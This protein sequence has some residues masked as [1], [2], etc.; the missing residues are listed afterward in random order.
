MSDLTGP[1]AGLRVV[2]LA[3][4]QAAMAA[5]LLG[6]LGAEVIVVEPPGGHRTRTY[7]PFVDDQPN[8]E[9]CLWWWYYNASKLGV[10]IDIDTAVGAATFGKLIATADIVI[11]G[12][13]P[14]R[15]AALSL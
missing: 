8:P 1:L 9:R 5:K 15:L 11:E 12:E 3:S 2:E 14:G 7:G 13:A 6:D 4:D 10:A